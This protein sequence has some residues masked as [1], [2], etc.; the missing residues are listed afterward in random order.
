MP[1]P[2]IFAPTYGP[3]LSADQISTVQPH[4]S[5]SE[6]NNHRFLGS[7]GASVYR[8]ALIGLC[9]SRRAPTGLVYPMHISPSEVMV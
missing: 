1:F 3:H 7:P 2:L 8:T 9:K 6:F 5:C 4:T